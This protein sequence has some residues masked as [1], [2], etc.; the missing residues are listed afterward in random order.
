MKREKTG[1]LTF[2]VEYKLQVLK[3]KKRALTEEE[4]EAVEAMKPIDELVPRP[5]PEEQK[6][7][8]E[9]NWFTKE[10]EEENNDDNVAE[11]FDDDI[12]M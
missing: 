2:N 3:C 10:E 4:R 9:K 6:A 7:F 12:P 11:E 8:I 5:T 1:P